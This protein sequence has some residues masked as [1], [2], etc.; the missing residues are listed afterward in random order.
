MPNDKRSFSPLRESTFL[1]II[2]ILA[3]VH[4][5]IYVFLVPAWQHYDEPNHFEY[6]W[7]SAHLN[8]L[9]TPDDDNP[10]LSHRV[11]TS[12]VANGFFIGMGTQPDLSNPDQE[13]K[14]PGYSQLHEP[15]GYYL[16]ASLPLRFLPI[17]GIVTQLHVLRLVSLALYLLTILAAWGIAR[18]LT[19]SAHPLRW[20]LPLSLVLL[21]GFTDVMTA[22]N[23]D[24]AA[25][26]VCSFFLWGSLRLIKRGF[27][28]V[29]SLWVLATA[30]MTYFVKN[31]AMITLALLPVVFLFALLRGKLRWLAWAALVIGVAAGLAFGIRRDDAA[32]WYRAVSQAEPTRFATHQAV[33]G[34]YVL[35]LD[36]QAEIT[37]A[38]TV[39][40]FQP[41]PT[42]TGQELQEKTVTLGA[43]MWANKPLS[44]RALT[45]N[46]ESRSFT[47]QAKL[48]VKPAFYAMQIT[49]PDDTQRTWVSLLKAPKGLQIFYDGFIL[50]EGERPL[51]EPPNF[52]TPEGL[53]GDWGGQPFVNLIRNP[54]IEKAGL[55]IQPQIDNLGARL[56]PDNT[57]PSWILT[58]MLDWPATGFVYKS[59]A[60]H[61]FQTFWARFG[62]GH[63]PLLGPKGAEDLPYQ[64]LAILT[65][66]GIC[67][68][69]VGLIHRRRRA[70]WEI[71]AVFSL[72]LLLLWGL[73]LLRGMTY[74]AYE[75][76]YGTV[77]RHAYPVIIPTMLIF[78]FGWFEIFTWVNSVMSRLFK[79]KATTGKT[80]LPLR[81]Q[82]LFKFEF[83]LYIFLFVAL[84]VLSL[85][86]IA[87]YYS[88]Q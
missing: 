36:T 60:R 31:T 14:I 44:L 85:A 48:D 74:L 13:I 58:S 39:P 21:P 88:R 19:P 59:S 79:N 77:A 7:L 62:W 67:G 34:E 5:L 50:A 20:I 86:S 56:L 64:I 40:M 70:S 11:V 15:P 18:E 35:R 6:A 84:D 71:V 32:N 83:A 8:R 66:V 42:K 23:N 30:G 33:L 68:A 52:T 29:D 22:V 4:G 61:L 49:L 2:L 53:Q 41:L 81:T 54:S 45:L 25:V 3:L 16:L 10:N 72:A 27:S 78:C 73:T 65:L 82:R 47:M 75:H 51:L 38:W 26:A 69:L 46:T 87:L 28:L 43:W 55:R 1:G 9:P 17:K 76:I 37:P 24:C 80:V 12:M 63:V 57:R